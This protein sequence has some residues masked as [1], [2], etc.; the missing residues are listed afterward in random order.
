MT[1]TTRSGHTDAFSE[2]KKQFQAAQAFAEA[3]QKPMKDIIGAW[4]AKN[5]EQWNA[6]DQAMDDLFRGGVANVS[7]HTK[8]PPMLLAD[9]AYCR[10]EETEFFAAGDF[11]GTPYRT[12]PARKKPLIQ[13]GTDYYAVDLM[14]CP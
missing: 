12:L 10:G 8:L 6:A 11:A 4:G 2:A 13:L 9:L 5:P 7:R 14:F 3:H 1:N